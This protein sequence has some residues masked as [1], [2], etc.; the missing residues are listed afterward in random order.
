MTP[1]RDNARLYI[2][3]ATVL[4]LLV[5]WIVGTRLGLVGPQYFPSPEQ[6]MAAA[7]QLVIGEGYADGRMHEHMLQSIKLILLGFFAATAIGVPLG[8]WMGWNRRAEALVN[9]IFL[10]VRPI[11]ALAW[12]TSAETACA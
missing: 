10:L 11:P 7:R 9:P 3:I 8:L 4:A 1:L 12:A 2:G 6:F 5:F